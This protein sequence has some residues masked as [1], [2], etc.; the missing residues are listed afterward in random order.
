[1]PNDVSMFEES[2]ISIA[3]GN[4]GPEVQAQ[5]NVVTRSHDDEGFARAVET[6]VLRGTARGG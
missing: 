4:A 3:M 2:G 5:A 6:F 1:M